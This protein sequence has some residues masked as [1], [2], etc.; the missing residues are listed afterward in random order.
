[1]SLLFVFAMLFAGIVA[2]QAQSDVVQSL[3]LERG[4][5]YRVGSGWVS[6][7]YSMLV[8]SLESGGVKELLSV[9]RRGAVAEMPGPRAA[10]QI[11]NPNPTFYIRGFS[12]ALGLHLVRGIEK[13]DYRE[14]R[15]PID[16]N[17]REWAHFADKDM[18]AVDLEL[19][20]SDIVSMKP[21]AGLPSGEYAITSV[22][23]PSGRS[24][25]IGAPG[26][27]PNVKRSEK[28]REEFRAGIV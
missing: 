14:L 1:M 26:P 25:H 5:Y 27:P 13:R 7:P 2:A 16:R 12:P 28:N 9:G 3:P 22:L 4:V 18:P 11:T 21:H 6:L 19:V 8:P 23:D 24:I 17:F 10:V 20:G 15:M